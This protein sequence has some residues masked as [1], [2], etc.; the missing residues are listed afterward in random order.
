M[1]PS[2]PEGEEEPLADGG[3]CW[4]HPWQLLALDLLACLLSTIHKMSDTQV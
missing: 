4:Y 2:V 3:S 1:M